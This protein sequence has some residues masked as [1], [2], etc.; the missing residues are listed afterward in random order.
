MN[1]TFY[2]RSIKERLVD[3]NDKEL[4]YTLDDICRKHAEVG[5]ESVDEMRKSLVD[6]E[7]KA[8][9][10][11]CETYLQPVDGGT[12]YT[13]KTV[14]EFC[15]YAEKYVY[16]DSFFEI[17]FTDGEPGDMFMITIND[18]DGNFEGFADF[19]FVP[20]EDNEDLYKESCRHH[21][22]KRITESKKEV[23]PHDFDTCLMSLGNLIE[24]LDYVCHNK[25]EV[26][27]YTWKCLDDAEA[28]SDGINYV[29]KSNK[30][31]L[32][33][34]IK[35]KR[36]N[37]LRPTFA[38]FLNNAENIRKEIDHPDGDYWSKSYELRNF[39]E[40]IKEISSV[41]NNVL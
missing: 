23:D 38:L 11:G 2:K 30:N 27:R 10:L 16:D 33:K 41:L 35:D 39:K 19:I 40:Y 15:K 32:N 17:T 14:G 1:R 28:L 22:T 25:P 13:K 12:R 29:L 18:F 24:D 5:F 26:P 3:S 4:A 7:K 20:F 31:D 37:D 9:N 6:I 36:M 34:T 8:F 21:N